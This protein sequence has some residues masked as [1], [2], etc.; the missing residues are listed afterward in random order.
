MPTSSEAIVYDLGKFAGE[1]LKAGRYELK[2]YDEHAP[3][4]PLLK[5]YR[6]ILGPGE[7]RDLG[8]IKVDFEGTRL[9]LVKIVPTDARQGVYVVAKSP[10]T[11]RVL[12]QF[13]MTKERQTL[14]LEGRSCDLHLTADGFRQQ[15]IR[16]VSTGEFEIRM[17]D[18]IQVRFEFRNAHQVPDGYTVEFYVDPNL[19]TGYFWLNEVVGI[20]AQSFHSPG[21]YKM[22]AKICHHKNRAKKV[23]VQLLVSKIKVLD[24]DRE[25]TFDL[26]IDL[27]AANA[28]IRKLGKK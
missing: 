16:D 22:K 12:T 4:R 2:V 3:K 1:R 25:Q 28:A 20:K 19:G 6:F 13:F 7:D 9:D 8:D 11:G 17:R 26:E 27:S 10:Q 18:G 15:V 14:F 21:T 5:G 23:D 24:L